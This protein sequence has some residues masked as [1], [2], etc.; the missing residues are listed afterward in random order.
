MASIILKSHGG[1]TLTEVTQSDGRNIINRAY[2]VGNRYKPIEHRTFGD[3]G[4]AETYYEEL[5]LRD[6]NPNGAA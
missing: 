5:V 2:A 4:S 6:L 3:M 1:I